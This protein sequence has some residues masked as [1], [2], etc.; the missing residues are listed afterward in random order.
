[1]PPYDVRAVTG[2]GENKGRQPLR[3]VPTLDQED[4]DHRIV[5]ETQL[6]AC[7]WANH[8]HVPSLR[9]AS[10]LALPK[11]TPVLTRWSCTQPPL[12]LEL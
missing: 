9:W 5:M 11:S 2:G 8:P 4:H 1:M 6:R 12:S 10:L 7:I 3:G